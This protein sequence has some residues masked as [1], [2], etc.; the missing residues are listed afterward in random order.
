MISPKV[1]SARTSSSAG[2]QSTQRARIGKSSAVIESGK[3]THLDS[4]A[5][6]QAHLQ[7]YTERPKLISDLSDM[8][9]AYC[10]ASIGAE[11]LKS[12]LSSLVTIKKIIQKGEFSPELL[13]QIDIE[14]KALMEAIE[15]KAFGQFV[16]DSSFQ[17]VTGLENRIEFTVSGL[18]LKRERLTNELVTLYINGRMLPLAFDRTISDRDLVRQFQQQA[19]Y[20]NITLSMK[21]DKSLVLGV[22]DSLWRVWD[23]SIY[24]SGQAGRYAAGAPMT[25]NVTPI[26][27][28]VEDV[29]RLDLRENTSV[30]ALDPAIQHVNQTY[31]N[32]QTTLG[33][34]NSGVEALLKLCQSSDASAMETV[35]A[36][37]VE[38]PARAAMTIYRNYNGPSRENVINL[39][40]E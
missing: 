40:E 17:P 5:W 34:Q 31:R 9:K 28:T 14:K 32:L 19:G 22:T 23:G 36:L 11:L 26:V 1:G 21:E 3:V 33:N 7:R 4:T 8:H 38:R 18:D 15:T 12:I 6:R 2:T 30:T 27:P 25:F 39:L 10:A 13:N 16:L 35:K 37:M 29:T 20:S 24:V